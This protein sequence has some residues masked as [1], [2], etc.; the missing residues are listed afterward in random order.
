M[1]EGNPCAVQFRSES[2]AGASGTGVHLAAAGAI[3]RVFTAGGTALLPFAKEGTSLAAQR[4]EL[5]AV[6]AEGL[7]LIPSQGAEIPQAAGCSLPPT[8]PQKK[9]PQH[10]GHGGWGGL[11]HSREPVHQA[12]QPTRRRRGGPGRGTQV[13]K[14]QGQSEWRGPQE[15]EQNADS[16]C[17]LP[18]VSRCLALCLVSL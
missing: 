9:P 8:A 12:A 4:I 5:R 14:K 2:P 15:G 10:A 3:G 7:A 17:C 18:S 11:C 16:R 6:T 1:E 13:R